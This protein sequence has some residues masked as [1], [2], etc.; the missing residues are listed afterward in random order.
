[1]RAM[2]DRDGARRMILWDI[3]GTLGMF[4]PAAR[5]AFAR[6]VHRATG[7]DPDGHGVNMMGM[8]DPQIALEIMATVGIRGEPARAFLPA[9]LAF[10]EEEVAAAATV[11]RS[12]VRVPPGVEAALATLAGTPGVVQTLLTGNLRP[13]ARVKVTAAALDGF[14]DLELGAYGSDRLNRDELV[15]VA[16]ERAERRLGVRFEPGEVWVIGDTARDLACA[17]AAG[18]RCLLVATGLSPLAELA[19][20]GADAT[21]ADLSDTAAVLDLLLG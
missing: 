19:P 13:N 8:T 12:A 1:M 7:R 16:L 9:A 5:Y 11:L 6:A 3:D 20:L 18:A 2:A 10:L 17:R 14:L 21:L 4:G 15:P